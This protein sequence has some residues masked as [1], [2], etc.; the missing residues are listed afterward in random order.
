MVV[1]INWTVVEC[2]QP[3]EC[4]RAC[5][6]AC[7]CEGTDENHWHSHSHVKTY[8]EADCDNY[9]WEVR[10]LG[11]VFHRCTERVLEQLLQYVPKSR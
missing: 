7:M 3:R 1:S 11:V 8:I 2:G 5:V 9:V 4:V 6:R 10:L